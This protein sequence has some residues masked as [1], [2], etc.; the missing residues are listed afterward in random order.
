MVRLITRHTLLAVLVVALVLRLGILVALYPSLFAFERTG[1]IHGSGAYDLYAANL[2]ASGVY[3]KDAPGV[4]DAH[5]P[6]LVSYVVAAVYATLGRSGFAVALVNIAFD[7]ISISALYVLCKRLL[8]NANPWLAPLVGL[9]YA[10]YPYLIFQN[11]TLIDTPL[12]M[13]LLYSWLLTFVLLRERPRFDRT[14]LLLA[15]ASGVLLG[16]IALTRTNAVMLAPL[17]AIWFLFRRS[18]WQTTLRLAVVA[19]VSA[20]V[21]TPWT[22]R[23]FEVFGTFVPIAL[24]GG[25]NLY[26]GNNALTVPIFRAG[27][28]V[29]WVP[30]PDDVT[31][32]VRIDR[33]DQLADAA[34]RYLRENPQAIPELMW[35]KFLIHWSIPVAPLRNPTTGEMSA[36][37]EMGDTQINLDSGGNIVSGDLPEGDPVN[38][39]SSSLFDVVGRGVHIAYFGGLFALALAG[40]VLLRGR[41]RDVSL[42][43]IVQ[44]ATTVIYVLFHPATRYRV[45]TDPL[46]FVL[47]AWALIA[48]VVWW[49]QRAR[50]P[51]AQEQ[52]A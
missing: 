9:M 33:N 36:L 29:Q 20:F 45:P 1:A 35:T 32:T 41:W 47:S 30:A 22:I 5:L 13:A 11:L 43:W 37:V 2:L 3:G 17:L 23:N 48:L 7:L 21:I 19:L 25:E 12:Y 40:C 18:L 51:S 31:T 4:A 50:S 39:Y 28:D 16:L 42:I 44:F 26:Q 8:P 24:N 34:W 46:L 27:Y 49:Q 10:C 52:P 6:P 15:I 14:A 38:V